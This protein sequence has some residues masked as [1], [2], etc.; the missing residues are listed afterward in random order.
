[1][2]ITK[3]SG[4]DKVTAAFQMALGAFL[5]IERWSGCSIPTH[6]NILYAIDSEKNNANVE[7]T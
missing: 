3:L 5:G 2:M 4:S 7:R 6:T 1:M